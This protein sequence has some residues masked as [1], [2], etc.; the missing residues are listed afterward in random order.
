MRE[1]LASIAVGEISPGEMLP[2]EVALAEHFD[3]SRGVIRECIRGLEERGVIVVKHGRGATVTAPEQWDVLDPEVLRALLAAPGGDALVA[4]ALECQRLL[5]VQA[6][7]LAAERARHED[8]DALTQALERMTVHGRTPA[9]DQRVLD[10]DVDFHRAIVHASGNRA[11]ARMSAPLHRALIAATRERGGAIDA[12]RQAADHREI[13]AAI[14]AGD[15]NAA[16]NATADHLAAA[17]RP[18]RRAAG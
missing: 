4:D 17:S 15:V 10:A 18:L 3:V 13:V 7:G 14:A 12:E 2:R 9:A 11:L 1:L 5:E 8:L 16:R 6:A